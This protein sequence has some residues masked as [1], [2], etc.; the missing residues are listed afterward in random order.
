VQGERNFHILY[1]LVAGT[2][3]LDADLEVTGLEGG[4]DAFKIL[5]Q[6]DCVTLDG[7]DDAEEF[8]TVKAAFDTIG[9]DAASQAQV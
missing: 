6:S 7:V 5:S 8:G 9:M 4:P 2:S 3:Q 1:Q